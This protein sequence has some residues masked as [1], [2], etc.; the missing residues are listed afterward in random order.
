MTAITVLR[1]GPIYLLFS[2]AC[3]TNL[4]CIRSIVYTDLL[5]LAGMSTT[6]KFLVVESYHIRPTVHSCLQTQTRLECTH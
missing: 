3:K 6:E 1:V 2:Y 5:M 4:K